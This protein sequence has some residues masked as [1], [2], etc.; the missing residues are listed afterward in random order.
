M[1]LFIQ[2]LHLTE[3]PVIFNQRKEKMELILNVCDVIAFEENKQT[4]KDRK[5]KS[6]N[7]DN[8]I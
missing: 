5:M 3:Q 4:H 7:R 1:F 8:E 6:T 2:N